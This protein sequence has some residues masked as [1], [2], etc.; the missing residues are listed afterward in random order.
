MFTPQINYKQSPT[1][2]YSSREY[3]H[4]STT[5]NKSTHNLFI[6]TQRAAAAF[7]IFPR[8]SE[9]YKF[10]ISNRLATPIPPLCI[11]Y[12]QAFITRAIRNRHFPLANRARAGLAR[13][14]R[15]KLPFS[16]TAAHTHTQGIIGPVGCRVMWPRAD[17]VMQR[18]KDKGKLLRADRAFVRRLRFSSPNVHALA[19]ERNGNRKGF[20]ERDS[21]KSKVG[22]CTGTKRRARAR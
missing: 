6:E 7:Q 17:R 5:I 18:P 11:R 10:D 19:F 9:L 21:Q 15:G 2:P 22:K 14:S 1:V 20:S 8:E 16:R 13:L 3:L 4:T 12:T